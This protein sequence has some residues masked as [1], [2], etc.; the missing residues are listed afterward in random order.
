MIVK[1]EFRSMRNETLKDHS[2]Q[3]FALVLPQRTLGNDRDT[4]I[5][6]P[7]AARANQPGY[8][9]HYNDDADSAGLYLV[10]AMDGHSESLARSDFGG[11]SSPNGRFSTE[12]QADYWYC[13]D[14]VG[15]AL[16]G[17]TIYQLFRLCR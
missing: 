12:S 17:W 11:H 10:V 13:S 8:H 9:H 15:L 14:V 2:S 16:C 5:I 1:L 6:P 3:Y 7:H 4:K